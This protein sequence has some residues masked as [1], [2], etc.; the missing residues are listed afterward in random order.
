MFTAARRRQGLSALLRIWQGPGL[1]V[2]W[3]KGASLLRTRDLP[4]V[5]RTPLAS[6]PATDRARTMRERVSGLETGIASVHQPH[7]GGP[8]SPRRRLL[9][10][11]HGS[12]GLG[13]HLRPFLRLWQLD[14]GQFV[15]MTNCKSCYYYTA[16][17]RENKHTRPPRGSP[18][19]YLN[20]GL[21]GGPRLEIYAT[22]P[23]QAVAPLAGGKE[24]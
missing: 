8:V 24:R 18:G 20:G 23:R 13:F 19:R 7:D 21:N 16:M 17:K 10:F 14:R 5:I 9:R 2:A 6:T 1:V 3:L 12:V 11:R 4:L 22:I 15:F